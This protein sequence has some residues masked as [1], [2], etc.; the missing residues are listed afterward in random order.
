MSDLDY[1]RENLKMVTARVPEVG[2]KPVLDELEAG[3][4]EYL[5]GRSYG[6]PFGFVVYSVRD[7]GNGFDLY[8][9]SAASSR[10]LGADVFNFFMDKLKRI[11]RE[12]GCRTISFHSPRRGWIRKLEKHGFEEVPQ[13][14]MRCRLEDQ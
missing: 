2:E 4:A 11:A 7:T 6:Q 10:L 12:R 9:L 14:T 3:R 1:I 13:I 8:I 5:M